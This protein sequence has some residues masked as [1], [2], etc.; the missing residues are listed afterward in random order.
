M[1]AA[2]DDDDDDDDDDNDDD[3]DD[4]DDDMRDSCN[5]CTAQNNQRSSL[6]ASKTLQF[7]VKKTPRSAVGASHQTVIPKNW[8]YLRLTPNPGILIEEIFIQVIKCMSPF[9]LVE[10]FHALLL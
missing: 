10:Q 1:Q 6:T 8:L 9:E 3:D 2:N 5:A 7:P 4:D